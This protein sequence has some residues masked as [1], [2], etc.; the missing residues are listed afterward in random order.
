MFHKTRQ[1]HYDLKV[2]MFFTDDIIKRKG[3]HDHQQPSLL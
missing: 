2:S 1:L 3:Q